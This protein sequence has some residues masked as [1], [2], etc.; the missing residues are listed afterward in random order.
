MQRVSPEKQKGSM[1]KAPV[2]SRLEI[3][4][5]RVRQKIAKKLLKGGH[6]SVMR[7]RDSW[8]GWASE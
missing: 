1:V 6:L 7:M 8:I 2:V 5:E 3:E 4:I